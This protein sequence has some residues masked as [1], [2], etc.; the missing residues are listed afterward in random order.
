MKNNSIISLHRSRRWSSSSL[1][2][3]WHA[4]SCD[5][6]PPLSLRAFVQRIFHSIDSPSQVSLARRRI[7]NLFALEM[8]QECT[9]ETY[10]KTRVGGKRAQT[11]Q[12][13]LLSPCIT[14][15]RITMQL[16]LMQNINLWMRIFQSNGLFS[17]ISCI[18]LRAKSRRIIISNDIIK[19]NRN[20]ERIVERIPNTFSDRIKC[21]DKARGK[22]LLFVAE[23]IHSYNTYA[24]YS[25]WTLNTYAVC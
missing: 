2:N 16:Q 23:P 4:V 8:S 17:A 1:V 14:I 18:T 20:T 3:A 9:Q 22:N 5:M 7:P 21:S 6:P 24:N 13:H 11:Q 15:K 10:Q 19:G 12:Q 25:N